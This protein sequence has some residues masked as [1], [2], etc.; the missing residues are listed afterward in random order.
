MNKTLSLVINTAT[1]RN[2]S[3]TFLGTIINGLLGVFFYILLARYLGPSDFGLF[4]VSV[5]TLT[6]IADTVDLGTN[7]GLVRHVA[8]NISSDANKALRFL[9]LGLEVKFFVWVLVLSCGIFSAP[10]IAIEIFKKPELV[11]PLKLVMLG[12]GGALFF[13]FAT[14]SLQAFQKYTLWSLINVVTNLLRVSFIIFFFMFSRL[15]LFNGL[16]LYVF[17]PFWGFSLALLFLPFKKILLV[18][19]EFSVAKQ[20][21][22]FNFWVAIFT[23]IAAIS[24]RLDTFLITRLLTSHEVGI[25]GA[26]NQ[27][28]QIIPQLV[29]AL[30]VVVAPIF[31]GFTNN[32]QMFTYFKKMQL[33]VLGLA[34]LGL[35]AILPSLYTIPVIFGPAYQESVVPFIFLTLAMLIFLI[36]IPVHS[37]VI[38][39]FARSDVFFWVS[40][41]HLF[42]MGVFG[43]YMISNFRIIG[44]SL[45][46]LIGMIFNF[47]VPSL[48]LI[49]KTKK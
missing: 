25:Y 43:Y 26:A 40:L 17:F 13:S 47:I 39:Y 2:L 19:N 9:K 29:G 11:L 46:V 22:K 23:C 16:L 37:S 34:G 27:L 35:L 21:F 32:N 5:T 41:G 15:D 24:S 14:S 30:G 38:F 7:T 33:L 28:I 10:F 45:T 49:L 48:W 42:I 20:F 36:S 44:A 4:T 6:F 3:I 18:K 12:V 8:A 1:F 31:S